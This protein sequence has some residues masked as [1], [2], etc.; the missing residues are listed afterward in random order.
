MKNKLL[1]LLFILIALTSCSKNDDNT[2][3]PE[4]EFSQHEMNVIEYFKEVALGFEFGNASKITRKWNSDINIFI[5]GEK[6]NEL[7]N[8]LEKIITEINELATDGFKINIVNNSSLSNYYIFFGSGK[9]YAQLYP[10]QV[11]L[12]DSNWG[13]FSIFWNSQ[14][15]LMLGH[16]YVDIYRANLVEQKHLLREELTQSL[17]LARDSKKYP[18]SIFQS[19]WTT[20]NKY[21]LIDSDLIRL[22]YHPNMSA[23]LTETQ[24]DEVL[25][26]ILR[27][28]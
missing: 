10:G 16:M 9:D 11:D 23:G 3:L 13:L 14:N 6:N 1:L 17:G 18:E 12:V 22:L 20:T 25:K 2:I 21:S 15:Q 28:E 7:I 26:E 4:S 8:E 5:G 27:N 24:V 19:E